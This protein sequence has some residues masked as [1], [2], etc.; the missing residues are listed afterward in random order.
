MFVHGG[1][2]AGNDGDKVKEAILSNFKD[3]DDI[4][5]TWLDFKYLLS[6]GKTKNTHQFIPEDE[7][8]NIRQQLDA[9]KLNTRECVLYM[10][11][12]AAHLGYLDMCSKSEHS[13][14]SLPWKRILLVGGTFQLLYTEKTLLNELRAAIDMDVISMFQVF[15]GR[16]PAVEKF[17]KKLPEF[18]ATIHRLLMPDER[19]DGF[20]LTGESEYLLSA[21][22]DI[23]KGITTYDG[24][25]TKPKRTP[26]K[27]LWF[28][29][30]NNGARHAQFFS[31]EERRWQS[32]SIIPRRIPNDVV[33]V[34][35]RN[36]TNT[37]G[38]ATSE[39][40]LQ[41]RKWNSMTE[42][43]FTQVGKCTQEECNEL[44]TAVKI[45]LTTLFK[46]HDLSNVRVEMIDGGHK[47]LR[48]QTDVY[49]HS[50]ASEEDRKRGFNEMLEMI[51]GT[52]KFK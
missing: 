3:I 18:K 1:P 33:I 6:H 14:I 2:Y 8:A 32:G 13:I 4:E 24:L 28:K 29:L 9:L 5:F 7:I 40:L 31:P 50:M 19:R 47:L 49:H 48:P 34:Y 39:Y 44:Y 16:Q 35:G 30:K 20:R 15:L 42:D 52:Y 46:K 27:E 10:H 37:Q 26:L 17:V 36:D 23:A 43:D 21:L 22:S 38:I 11:S 41:R 45:Y 51:R 25:S 12:T